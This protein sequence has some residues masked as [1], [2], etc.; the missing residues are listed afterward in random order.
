MEDAPSYSAVRTLIGVL[1]EK[2][3]VQRRAEGLRY[4]YSPVIGREE[5]KRAAVMHL[6]ETYRGSYRQNV[7]AVAFSVC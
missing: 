5:A 1:E 2:G 6:L 3:H 4:V 7:D